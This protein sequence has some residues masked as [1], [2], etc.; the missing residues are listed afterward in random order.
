MEDYKYTVLSVVFKPDMVMIEASLS[1]S[2]AIKPPS[3]HTP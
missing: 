1:Y 2:I 3:S